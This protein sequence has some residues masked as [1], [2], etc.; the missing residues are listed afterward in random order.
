MIKGITINR[1]TKILLKN[2]INSYIN[3]ERFSSREF[4]FDRYRCLTI[5][6][7]LNGK[8]VIKF[9]IRTTYNDLTPLYTIA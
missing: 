9:N 1:N 3:K 7:D 5:D 6:D 8:L 4:N 2:W